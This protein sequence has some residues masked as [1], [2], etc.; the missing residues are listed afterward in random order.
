MIDFVETTIDYTYKE[1]TYIY[2]IY[3]QENENEHETQR[4]QHEPLLKRRFQS[5]P[6]VVSIDR[7][8]WGKGSF[9]V[10]K[11]GIG[12][13]RMRM[14]EMDLLQPVPLTPQICIYA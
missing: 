4:L 5:H 13:L 10:S 12:R 8:L 14:S 9:A 7:K 2:L 6:T 1:L 11:T 3:D